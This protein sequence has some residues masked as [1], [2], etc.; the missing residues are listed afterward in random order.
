MELR[1]LGDAG[2]AVPVVGAGS[3]RVFDVSED[4]ESP[5][6]VVAEVLAAGGKLFDCSPMYGR[7]ETVLS[8]ALGRRRGEAIIASKIWARQPSEGRS[9]LERQLALFA[10]HVE[11]QQIHN[12]VAWREHLSWLEEAREVGTVGLI[13]ATHFGSPST[14]HSTY[15]DA[16][17][18]SELEEVMRS[19]RVQVIQIPLNPLER[20]CERRVLPLAEELGLGV[21]VMR[22][23]GEGALLPGPSPDLLE[24]LGVRTWT[25][26]LLKWVLSDPRVHAVIPATGSRRHARDN[27]ESGSPPWFDTE[28]RELVERLVGRYLGLPEPRAV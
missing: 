1:Q 19:G 6:Q 4:T 10:G 3:W 24:P 15:A 22:P 12:L 17:S 20:E 2:P 9:Q 14:H 8:R 11:L 25:Q 13:G 18:F 27:L 16:P 23:F 28:Q 7:A 26:A 5:N 21:I